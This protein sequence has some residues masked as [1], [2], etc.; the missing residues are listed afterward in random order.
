[1]FQCGICSVIVG[2]E[3]VLRNHMK[4]AHGI[5]FD[6]CFQVQVLSEVDPKSS[7]S[8]EETAELIVPAAYNLESQ[9]T[10]E[11]TIYVDTSPE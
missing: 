2:T 1:M 5:G 7:R 9:S 6:Q 8:S 3:D 11:K 4:A 10:H